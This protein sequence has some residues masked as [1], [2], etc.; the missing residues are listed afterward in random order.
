MVTLADPDAGVVA[1]SQRYDGS[2]RPLETLG[3]R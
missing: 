1:E 2:E 3:Y